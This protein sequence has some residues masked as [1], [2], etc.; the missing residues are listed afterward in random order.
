MSGIRNWWLAVI[1]MTSTK[2]VIGDCVMPERK[3]TMPRASSAEPCSTG[4]NEAML[5]PIP[6]PTASAG[7]NTP[8][9]MPLRKASSTVAAL[10]TP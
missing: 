10:A 5:L 8:P 1:S 2:E 6:A 3:A 9:G 7:A 4:M